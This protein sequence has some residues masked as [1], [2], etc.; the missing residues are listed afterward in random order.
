MLSFLFTFT[1]NGGPGGVVVESSDRS[2]SVMYA[3][4]KTS[5]AVPRHVPGPAFEQDF[6]LFEF[7]FVCSI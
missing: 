2:N 6:Y 1:V 4:R 3:S 7:S 5:K